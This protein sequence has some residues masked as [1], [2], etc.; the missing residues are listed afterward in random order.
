MSAPG[1]TRLLDHLIDFL[2]ADHIVPNRERG[3]TALSL[4]ETGVVGNVV[5][6]PDPEL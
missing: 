3:R 2:T 1:L 6:R 4:G 5:L